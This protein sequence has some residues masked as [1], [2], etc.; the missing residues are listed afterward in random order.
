MNLV[1]R[2]KVVHDPTCIQKIGPCEM[3]RKITCEQSARHRASDFT[4]REFETGSRKPGQ[5][6]PRCALLAGPS[7]HIIFPNPLDRIKQVA[8][9]RWNILTIKAALRSVLIN[10]PL[11]PHKWPGVFNSAAD[12][13]NGLIF[14]TAVSVI[15][16]KVKSVER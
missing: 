6:L 11:S 13:P 14:H 15:Y 16:F 9:M 7:L 1:A 12:I 2:R 8:Q 4:Q 5:C 10:P 3:E